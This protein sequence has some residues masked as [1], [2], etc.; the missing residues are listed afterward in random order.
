LSSFIDSSLYLATFIT[1]ILGASFALHKFFS[2]VTKTVKELS[3]KLDRFFRDWD[4]TPSEPG[5]DAIPGVMERLNKV[6][7][8]LSKNGGKSVKDTVNRIEKR[9]EEGSQNFTEL[10]D[11]VEKIEGKLD[12]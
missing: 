10:Y 4:G 2:P 6:D 12:K 7:G 9:L 1:A 8:E 11:R 5:R 3:D